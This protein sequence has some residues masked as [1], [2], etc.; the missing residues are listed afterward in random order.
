MTVEN[1]IRNLKLYKEHAD[2]AGLPGHVR[3]MSQLNYD[4][5]KDKILKDKRFV[6]HPI[7]KE[8]KPKEKKVKKDVKK[9]KR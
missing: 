2:N 3:K 1:C 5:L 6:D 4:N 9:S 7:L 8:L